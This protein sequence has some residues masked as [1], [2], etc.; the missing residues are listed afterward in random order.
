MLTMPSASRS[1]YRRKFKKHVPSPRKVSLRSSGWVLRPR[2]GLMEDCGLEIGHELGKGG[3][4]ETPIA[5][6]TGSGSSGSGRRA[7]QQHKQQQ[8]LHLQHY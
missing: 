8:K 6:T 4:W 1:R 2:G 5:P 7:K 3:Q